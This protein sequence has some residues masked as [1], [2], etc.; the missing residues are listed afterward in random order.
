MLQQGKYCFT[1]SLVDLK[2]TDERLYEK[3]VSKPL[4]ILAVMEEAVQK[5]VM[6]K[7]NEF[8]NYDG[9]S[10]WQVCILSEENPKRLRDIESRYVNNVFVISGIIISCTKPY[11]K[12]PELKIKSKGC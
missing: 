6:E 8:S 11:I 4:E 3:F 2:Q 9:V 10:P 12:A 1:L 5:Y 7:K